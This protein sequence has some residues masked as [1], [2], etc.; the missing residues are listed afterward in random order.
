MLV[1]RKD[2]ELPLVRGDIMTLDVRLLK[3]CS[4]TSFRCLERTVEQHRLSTSTQYL[5][6]VG[7]AFEKFCYV[8]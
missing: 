8:Y 3:L 5:V 4:S 7:S 2:S 6:E 1:P